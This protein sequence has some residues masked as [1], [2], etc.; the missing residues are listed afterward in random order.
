MPSDTST[1]DSVSWSC[2]LALPSMVFVPLGVKVK[3]PVPP[4]RIM[5]NQLAPTAEAKGSVNVPTPLPQIT[6]CDRTVE[7]SVALL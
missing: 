6:S 3:I 4:L 1:S 5:Q 7:G 2:W